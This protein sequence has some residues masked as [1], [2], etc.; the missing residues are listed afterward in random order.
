MYVAEPSREDRLPV[1]VQAVRRIQLCALVV[2]SPAGFVASHLP[3]LLRDNS[4][5]SMSLEGHVARPNDLWRVAQDRPLS[6]AIFQGPQAYVHP[7]WFPTKRQNG[8][9]VPTW[10]YIAVHLHGT[11]EAVDEERWLRQHLNELTAQ[12]ERA[13]PE[14]WAI[15]D[16][17][18]DYIAA[19]L[20]GIVGI[21]MSVERFEGNWKMAQRQP[22]ENRLGVMDGLAR[23][24]SRGDQEVAATMRALAT[25]DATNPSSLTVSQ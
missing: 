25:G 18:A 16:A 14:P 20:K 4:D 2:T 9:A 17:P 23:S 13:R 24:P 7:G 3:M 21:R 19:M 10:N 12:N 1:L 8:R 5:G 11:L 6:L 15:T 22:L